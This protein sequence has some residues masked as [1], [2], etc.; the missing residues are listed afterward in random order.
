MAYRP[1]GQYSQQLSQHQR[2][3]QHQ[4]WDSKCGNPDWLKQRVELLCLVCSAGQVLLETVPASAV[5]SVLQSWSGGAVGVVGA[6]RGLAS[7]S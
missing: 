1:G 7:S 2:T 6:D 5:F 3:I 4:R